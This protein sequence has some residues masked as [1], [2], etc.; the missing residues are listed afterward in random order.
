[1][2][3]GTQSSP[4][5]RESGF[6][7]AGK[8][9]VWNP[10]SL[11]LESVMQVLLTRYSEFSTWNPKSKA[12][13]PESKTVL[14]SLTWGDQPKR[15][16]EI[17]EIPCF[18]VANYNRNFEVQLHQRDGRI[19]DRTFSFSF[20][21]IVLSLLCLTQ[22]RPQVFVTVLHKH[23]DRPFDSMNIWLE[24]VKTDSFVVCLRE[25][26]SFDG[27]HSGLKVVS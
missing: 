11:V 4:L 19:L 25:F 7:N 24:D 15:R 16:S 10:G 5:V 26:M 1:M 13:N 9:C 12:Q 27:S 17:S 14:D 3:E 21:I 8:F 2:E 6:R 20:Q 23:S 22:A 18:S